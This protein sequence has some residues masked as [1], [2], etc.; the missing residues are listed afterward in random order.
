MNNENIALIL[1]TH[2]GGDN[3]LWINLAWPKHH[4]EIQE[5]QKTYMISQI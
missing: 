4:Q 3:K 1:K 2:V 5:A